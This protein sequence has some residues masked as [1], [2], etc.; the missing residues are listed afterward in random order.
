MSKS[1][2]TLNFLNLVIAHNELSFFEFRNFFFSF[3]DSTRQYYHISAFLKRVFE[4][5]LLSTSSHS[6]VKLCLQQN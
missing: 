3:H 5:I 1:Q 2:T 6:V 4:Y